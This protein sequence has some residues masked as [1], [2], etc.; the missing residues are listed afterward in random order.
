MVPR[1]PTAAVCRSLRRSAIASRCCSGGQHTP[2]LASRSSLTRASSTTTSSQHAPS[3]PPPPPPPSSATKQPSDGNSSTFTTVSPDEVSHFNALA[4]SWW[5]PHGPSRIL[6]LMNPLRHDFIRSIR[7]SVGDTYA[8]PTGSPVSPSQPQQQG[9]RYLDIGCGGGIFAESAARLPTTH[10]V[11]AIDPTPQVLAIAQAHA[12]RDPLLN[13]A[14]SPGRLTYLNTSIEHLP[15]PRGG[16]DGSDQGYDIV[17]VFEVLE[18]V[19]SPAEF[20]DRC[21]PFVRPGG[22]LVMSTIARTWMSWFTTNLMAEDVLR[23]VPRGTHD[24]NKYI[25]EHELRDHFADVNGAATATEAGAAGTGATAGGA[26]AGAGAGAAGSAVWEAPRCMGVIYVPGV[27]WR[28]VAGSEKVGNY[29][30]A[31]RKAPA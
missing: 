21:T 26:I 17:S 27:G 18:H 7:A 16:A 15:V 5:D 29:F 2:L 20:L 31:I 19:T 3:P 25:N 23:I 4:S 30:F 22:W 10:S 9:L 11:T 24:W 13:P 8:A 1:I 14:L 12:K 28:E 6:H